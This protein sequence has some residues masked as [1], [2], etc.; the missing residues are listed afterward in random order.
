[1]THMMVHEGIHMAAQMV[2]IFRILAN[3]FVD[4]VLNG[5]LKNTVAGNCAEC[6]AM[7][8][9]EDAAVA[10][11]RPNIHRPRHSCRVFLTDVVAQIIERASTLRRQPHATLL[12]QP[13]ALSPL[14]QSLPQIT[15]GRKRPCTKLV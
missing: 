11:I 9:S 10:E 12:A 14:F 8:W 15:F 3:L 1:M 13:I 7:V 6:R 5:L 4:D 2:K